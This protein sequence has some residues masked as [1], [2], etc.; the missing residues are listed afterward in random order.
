[1][2]KGRRNE[3]NP[4]VVKRKN[5]KA[6]WYYKCEHLLKSKK[7]LPLELE[8]LK[9]Q[10]QLMKLRENQISNQF[11]VSNNISKNK[12]HNNILDK[13]EHLQEQIHCKEIVNKMLDNTI[14]SLSAD[15]LT[16]YHLRYEMEKREKEV[17][18]SMLISRS[19]YFHLQKKMVLKAALLLGIPVPTEEQGVDHRSES[20]PFLD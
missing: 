9:L 3:Q 17:W 19:A 15:E 11:D 8:N 16:V 6:D 7:N 4:N 12:S 20:G 10:L 2:D 13:M 14:R 5:R 1:M 18:D